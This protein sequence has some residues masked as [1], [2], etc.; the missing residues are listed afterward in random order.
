MPSRFTR[1]LVLALMF[2]FSVL[3]L[4]LTVFA[5]YFSDLQALPLVEPRDVSSGVS[6]RL[7]TEGGARD[8]K[9]QIK[10]AYVTLLYGGFLLGARVLG[11]SLK[12]T[13]TRKELIALCTETVS[14]TTKQVLRKDGWTIR[15]ILNI[16]SP[17]DGLS[18][19]GSYFSGIF[20]KL[21]V[22]NMT[23]YDRIVYLDSDV[24]VMSN[25]DHMFDCGTFC[26]AFRHSDLFN[27]GI[28]VVEP[29]SAIFSDM[30]E[31]ISILPS[32]DDGDQGFLN[33]YFKDLVYAPFFNWSNSSR[34]YQPMRM[35]A[36]LN[37]DIG[38]YYANSRWA[39][40]PKE[41]RNIHYTLGPVKP[42]I[43]W[44]NFLFNLNVQWT[45]VR[46]RL[47]QY[48]D[49][50]DTYLPAYLPIFWAPIP[51]LIL[52]YVG[53]RFVDRWTGN[54]HVS[55]ALKL[56]VYVN[57]RFSQFFPLPVVVLCYYLAYLVVPT[58][59]LP[60]QA[61]YVFWLWSNFFILILVG[62]YCY[63]CHV[64]GKRSDGHHHNIPR[65]KLWLLVLY[66]VFTTSYIL[67]KVVTP[68]VTPF[69]KRVKTFFL[70]LSLHLLVTQATGLLLITLLIGFRK[71][72]QS[73]MEMKVNGL[74]ANGSI[75]CKTYQ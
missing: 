30:L 34:Q 27:A 59:M 68:I 63:L 19:R 14:D 12:E 64:T 74:Q 26:A 16:H 36:G 15:P 37:S 21:H 10:D 55:K 4:G 67:L 71:G 51:F 18:K 28:I 23:D 48:A 7:A 33:V 56:F 75:N 13:G 8:H 42:W 72:A 69:S 11:Q 35:P 17:Y 66:A 62:L 57:G 61:E 73:G 25:I 47:S 46:K 20:S 49:Q 9:K 43:W 5:F 65:K 50:N 31:K 45:N 53:V 52:L 24:L 58:T 32:Y 41:I 44:T 60:A 54:P 39:I 38:S 29:N 6:H 22:W 70:L 1:N 2:N 40:P 3:F